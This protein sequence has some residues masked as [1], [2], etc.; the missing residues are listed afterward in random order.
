MKTTLKTISLIN[1]HYEQYGVKPDT[2]YQVYKNGSFF[3]IE[4]LDA[5]IYE[6]SDLFVSP[7]DILRELKNKVGKLKIQSPSKGYTL[8]AMYH[9]DLVVLHLHS[10]GNH[11]NISGN[12]YF[13]GYNVLTGECIGQYNS[14][15][16]G[17]CLMKTRLTLKEHKDLFN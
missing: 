11:W 3:M 1:P 15:S 5:F 14:M 4:G 7:A 16:T 8:D 17:L 13:T 2:Y 12:H 6:L 10:K 9:N